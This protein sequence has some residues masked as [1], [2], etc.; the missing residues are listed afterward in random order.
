MC[1]FLDMLKCGEH[2]E[3][4]AFPGMNLKR[5]WLAKSSGSTRKAVASEQSKKHEG[6]ARSQG[7]H[8]HNRIT[9][10]I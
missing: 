3:I 5:A 10:F 6:Q 7:W 1:C 9:N 2:D 4:G 8:F